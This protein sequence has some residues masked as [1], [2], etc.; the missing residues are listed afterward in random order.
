MINYSVTVAGDPSNSIPAVLDGSVL[1][2]TTW[3]KSSAPRFAESQCVYTSA[4]LDVE[5]WQLWAT[6]MAAPPAKTAA[7]FDG[8]SPL[9]PARFPNAKL[10]DDSAFDAMPSGGGS[11]PPLSAGAN[12][13]VTN[14]SMLYSTKASTSGR[15]V[16]DGTHTPSMASS[17][18]DFAGAIA[19]VP[20]GT[21]G[22]LTQGVLSDP[23]LGLTDHM[24]AS[25]TLL[26]FTRRLFRTLMGVPPRYHGHGLPYLGSGRQA[27]RRGVGIL[28]H[29]T[30]G[31]RRQGPREPAVLLRGQ[32]RVARQRVGVVCRL[33]EA[34]PRLAR[35]LCRPVR[36][37]VPGQ[38]ASVP[39]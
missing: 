35:R 29:S 23:G 27:R 33:A 2:S 31:H 34:A 15:I 19:V 32:L 37:H 39:C 14:G 6:G 22:S 16:E 12:K 26:F 3:T 1:I 20:L 9:T 4:P 18:I 7:R 11:I 24:C 17:G 25:C 28:V 36:R 21:M 30:A 5:V 8:F 38:D 10:S 13:A